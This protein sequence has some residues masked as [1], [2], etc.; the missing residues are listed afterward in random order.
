[1]EDLLNGW[2]P[3]ALLITVSPMSTPLSLLIVFSVGAARHSLQISV[4]ENG[5]LDV[6][7]EETLKERVTGLIE[8][9]G[10]GVSI[11]LLRKELS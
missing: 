5:G 9:A 10:V 6:D 4:R 8:G 7:V 1:M 2:T 11:E 3:T